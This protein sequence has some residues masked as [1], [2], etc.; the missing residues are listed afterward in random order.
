MTDTVTNKLL[1]ERLDRLQSG[2]SEIE[3]DLQDIKHC[4]RSS[5][6]GHTSL[7]HRVDRLLQ[8]LERLE[9]RSWWERPTDN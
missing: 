7:S 6:N 9:R 2:L 4:L 5:A 1:L 3:A 8:R